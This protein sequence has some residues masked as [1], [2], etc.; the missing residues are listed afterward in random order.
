MHADTR[1]HTHALRHTQSHACTQTHIVAFSGL[2]HDPLPLAQTIRALPIEFDF[3]PVPLSLFT[4][5]GAL[6]QNAARTFS[7]K[8]SSD[9]VV[10]IAQLCV[11]IMPSSTLLFCPSRL[12][13]VKYMPPNL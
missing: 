4:R 9:E 1:H 8:I 13:A 7:R 6:L 5:S 2:L 12:Q 11:E 3:R 10:G